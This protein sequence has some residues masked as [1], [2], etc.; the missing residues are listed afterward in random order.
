MKR[1]ARPPCLVL[2]SLLT[3]SPAGEAIGDTLAL[4]D[5]TRLEGVIANRE[6]LA[7]TPYAFQNVAILVEATGEY[8][9]APVNDVLYVLLVDGDHKRLLDVGNKP[10]ETTA[11]VTRTHV[12]PARTEVFYQPRPM[13]KAGLGISFPV[14]SN[15][16]QRDWNPGWSGSAR[17]CFPLNPDARLNIGVEYNRYGVETTTHTFWGPGT[18]IDGGEL[19]ILYVPIEIQMR[20]PDAGRYFPSPYFVLGGGYYRA[21]I[22]DG[23]IAVGDQQVEL[24]G[25][26]D[27]TL[28]FDFGAGIT[29]RRWFVEGLCVW[30]ME[31]SKPNGE[32]TI[33]AGVQVDGS[34]FGRGDR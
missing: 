5:G 8:R 1:F 11:A 10:V 22:E 14:P 30:G 16:F 3:L 18:V 6:M 4:R 15:S 23:W 19:S 28:G 34:S 24:A 25:H 27:E 33:R 9:V 7:S 13:L 21:K 12:L 2:L 20:P 17:I 32:W 29:A 31:D 26:L